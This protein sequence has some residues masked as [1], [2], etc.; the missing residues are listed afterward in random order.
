MSA[1]RIDEDAFYKVF[2]L[3]KSKEWIA[4]KSKNLLELFNTCDTSEQQDLIVHLLDKFEL[5][6]S[7]E[8]EKIGTDVANYIE[9]VWELNPATTFIIAT[10]DNKDRNH[11]DGS[12]AFLQNLKNKFSD[13]DWIEDNFVSTIG[14][15]ATTIKS[16]NTAI[17]FDDFIGSG[18]TILRKYVWFAD[19]MKNTK[20]KVD[21]RIVTYAI[22]KEALEML[23]SKGI[24]IYA[25]LE[26]EKGISGHFS[27]PLLTIYKEGMLSLEKKLKQDIGKYYLDSYSL[28]YKKCETIFCF[29]SNNISDNVFPIFWWPKFSS[30]EKRNPFFKRL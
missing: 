24:S 11:V 19:K 22:M 4:S 8:L 7:S 20:K 21:I 1:K 14:K 5:V 9:N 12:V 2:P 28:G 10:A 13:D 23:K 26:L 29:E 17:L 16:G 6:T 25:G 18:E 27:E 3:I 30:D 15:G